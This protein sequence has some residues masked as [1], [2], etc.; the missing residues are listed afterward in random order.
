[1]TCVCDAVMLYGIKLYDMLICYCMLI[2]IDAYRVGLLCLIC[3][4]GVFWPRGSGLSEAWRNMF[5]HGRLT[6][7]DAMIVSMVNRVFA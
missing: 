3:R 5:C 6:L 7:N 4:D 2:C 1:M